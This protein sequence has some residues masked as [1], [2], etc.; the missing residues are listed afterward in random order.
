MHKIFYDDHSPETIFD[1]IERARH[2]RDRARVAALADEMA[3]L[4]TEYDLGEQMVVVCRYLAK[5]PKYR[6]QAIH[7][8]LAKRLPVAAR[9]IL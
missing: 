5:S 3:G 2:K 7:F 1:R 8:I 9:R 4:L 6:H